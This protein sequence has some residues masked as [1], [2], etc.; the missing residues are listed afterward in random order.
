MSLVIIIT[1]V[2]VVVNN[3]NKYECDLQ[4]FNCSQKLVSG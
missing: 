3:N 1:I 4:V 2:L